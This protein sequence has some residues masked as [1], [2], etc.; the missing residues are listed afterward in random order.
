[1]L[2]C[3]AGRICRSNRVL[4]ELNATPGETGRWRGCSVGYW[5]AA[6]RGRLA[7]SLAARA[8][9]GARGGAPGSQR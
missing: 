6:R 7:R 9:R 8:R 3:H 2:R 5:G 4:R 1:M